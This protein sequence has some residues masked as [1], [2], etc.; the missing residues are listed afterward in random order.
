MRISAL[1]A[2]VLL[3]PALQTHGL[4]EW[5][6]YS[7]VPKLVGIHRLNPTQFVAVGYSNPSNLSASILSTD[8]EVLAHTEFNIP[9]LEI[10]RASHMTADGQLVVVGEL[11]VSSV[12]EHVPFAAKFGLPGFSLIWR[13]EYPKEMKG[14]LPLGG[15]LVIMSTRG[16]YIF[17]GGQRLVFRLLEISGENGEAIWEKT[18][19]HSTDEKYGL[20]KTA[21]DDI[22]VF[23]SDYRKASRDEYASNITCLGP[24]G[25]VRA[26]TKLENT[27]LVQVLET[28]GGFVAIGTLKYKHDIYVN[29]TACAYMMNTDLTLRWTLLIPRIYI[30]HNSKITE[31]S[32]GD[33]VLLT[34]KRDDNDSIMAGAILVELHRNGTVGWRRSVKMFESSQRDIIEL[35]PREYIMLGIIFGSNCNANL[36]KYTVP[37]HPERFSHEDISEIKVCPLGYYWNEKMCV[38]CAP[39]CDRCVS[40]TACVECAR[41]YSRSNDSAGC[42]RAAS[43]H[44]VRCDCAA[45]EVSAECRVKCR[46]P[47][48]CLTPEDIYLPVSPKNGRT[49]LC[50]PQTLDNGTHCIHTISYPC[51]TLCAKCTAE[52]ANSSSCIECMLSPTVIAYKS[53][54]FSVDCRCRPGY[55]LNSSACAPPAQK[56]SPGRVEQKSSVL[57]LVWILVAVISA[58]L[59]G[60]LWVAVRTRRERLGM[61]RV[62]SEDTTTVAATASTTPPQSVSRGE[63]K[64]EAVELA[65]VKKL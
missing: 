32:D 56:P 47:T 49:C 34:T 16:T 5:S 28:N 25:T 35:S 15:S 44:Q 46:L 18:F 26:Q 37:E 19:E 30:D 60:L 64:Q 11:H 40:L 57:L 24:N 62:A 58:I 54:R 52:A 20:G 33:F 36:G 45:G 59:G 39:Y 53:G 55:V 21:G 6:V 23:E 10:I 14:C 27:T 65:E 12:G 38:A 31:T 51:P 2:L 61:T 1:F 9:K 42:V 41:G 13:K 4:T 22:M 50:P 63:Q 7:E 29:S 3:L 48:Y 43:S 8:G 17:S